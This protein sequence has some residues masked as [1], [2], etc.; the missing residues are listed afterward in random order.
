MSTKG[1]RK[2]FTYHGSPGTYP[3]LHA[4]SGHPVTGTAWVSDAPRQEA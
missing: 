2:R 1:K 3:D 4:R